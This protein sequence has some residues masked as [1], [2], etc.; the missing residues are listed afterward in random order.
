MKWNEIQLNPAITYIKGLVKIMFYTEVLFIVNIQITMKIP[1]GSKIYMLYWR[2][3]V[4]SGCAIAGFYCSRMH[5]WRNL[6]VN[7]KWN[8]FSESEIFLKTVTSIESTYFQMKISKYIS[9]KENVWRQKWFDI[10]IP[11]IFFLRPLFRALWSFLPSGLPPRFSLHTCFPV[12]AIY[13]HAKY[14]CSLRRTWV[15]VALAKS[16]GD[17]W[18]FVNFTEWVV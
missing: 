11:P 3:Y 2:N 17:S 8:L 14:I 13:G 12:Y 16:S 6:D 10:P 9:E 15:K 4:K 1:Q 5:I 18:L 7:L